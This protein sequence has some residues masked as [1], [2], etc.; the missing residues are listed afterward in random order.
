MFPKTVAGMVYADGAVYRK[1]R[2]S[3]YVLP[4][5]VRSLP[6]A[7]ISLWDR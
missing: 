5:T 4:V 1:L 7:A 6:V 2:Y 3:H